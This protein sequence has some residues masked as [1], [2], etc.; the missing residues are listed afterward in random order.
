M[1]SE[2]FVVVIVVAV[3]ATVAIPQ[4]AR[5]VE[6]RRVAG[7]VAR[8]DAIKKA[9]AMHYSLNGSYTA[10]LAALAV[11]VPEVDDGITGT[12]DG[13]WDYTITTAGG[14]NAS[15]VVT[16]TRVTGK[17]MP[18]IVVWD[19]SVGTWSGTHPLRPR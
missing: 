11:E 16:A 14:V 12:S 18:G 19:S 7:V 15:Y 2:L 10:S 13:Q 6:R 8:F 5:V 4:F 9:E 3:L 1:L 17:G